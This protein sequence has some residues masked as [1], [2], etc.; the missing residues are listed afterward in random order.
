[1]VL[2]DVP[3]SQA[4]I[5]RSSGIARKAGDCLKIALA[6]SAIDNRSVDCVR[7][8]GICRIAEFEFFRALRNS[9]LINPSS[10]GI[11]GIGRDALIFSALLSLQFECESALR[12]GTK[13]FAPATLFF[14][15]LIFVRRQRLNTL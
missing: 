6:T 5:C 13:F 8:G 15:R 12:A 4:C 2:C 11:L 7:R 10:A 1:M 9:R 14:D 3:R